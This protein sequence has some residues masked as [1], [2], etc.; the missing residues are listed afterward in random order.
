MSKP[1]TPCGA[2][3][4]ENTSGMTYCNLIKGHDGEH[5]SVTTGTTWEAQ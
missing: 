4:P 3:C 2:T 5:F 1:A